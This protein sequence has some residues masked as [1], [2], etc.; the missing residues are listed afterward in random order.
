MLFVFLTVFLH[1]WLYAFVTQGYSKSI[2]IWSVGCILAE[3]LSNKPIFPGKHYLDQLNHI[4]G[5]WWL[6]LL[7]SFSQDAKALSC[8]DETLPCVQVFLDHHLKKIWIASLTQRLGTTCSPS[9]TDPEFLGII[10]TEGQMIMVQ[11]TTRLL[12]LKDFREQIYQYFCQDLYSKN[13]LG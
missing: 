8:E 4:L 9:Q 13:C 1:T 11:R 2:D 6:L 5:E 10:S 7:F 12:F 3:M